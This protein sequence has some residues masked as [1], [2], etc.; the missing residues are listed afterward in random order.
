MGTATS[1]FLPFSQSLGRGRS[2]RNVRSTLVA[3]GS[4]VRGTN[5]NA[6]HDYGIDFS[7]E[8]SRLHVRFEIYKMLKAYYAISDDQQLT[9]FINQFN[10]VAPF[11]SPFKQFFARG[12]SLTLIKTASIEQT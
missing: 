6:S 12:N 10:K 8:P 7:G 2:G 3:P 11:L 5:H 9:S 1:K 4:N